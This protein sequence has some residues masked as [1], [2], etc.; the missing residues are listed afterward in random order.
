LTEGIVD[1]LLFAAGALL[2]VAAVRWWR[3]PAGGLPKRWAAAHA[4]LVFAFFGVPLTTA[5]NQAPVDIAYQFQPWRFQAEPD[6]EPDNRLLSDIPLQMVPFRTLVRDRLLAGEAPLWSH[7]TGT[8][9][10]LLGNAQSAPFAPLHLATLP[11]PPVRALTVAAAWQVLVGAL[12]MHA[13][14]LALARS[15]TPTHWPVHA[16]A[17]LAAVAFALSTYSVAWL[18][19]P[20]SMV[21]MFIPGVVLG[22]VGLARGERRAFPALVVCAW[23]LAVSGHPETA[24]HTGLLAAGL[25]LVYLAAGERAGLAVGRGRFA[26]RAALAALLTACLAAP[27][28]LPVVEILPESERKVVLDDLGRRPLGMPDFE[29]RGLLP[30]AQPL[31]FGSPRDGDW[32]GPANFNE[33]ASQYAGTATLALALAGALI[34]VGVPGRRRGGRRLTAILAAGLFALLAGLKVSPA[35][36]LVDALPLLEHAA[37]GRLRLFWVLAAALVAGLALPR[38]ARSRFGVAAGLA[39]LAGTAAVL[40][41]VLPTGSA[42]QRLWWWVALAGLGAVAAGVAVPRLR[43]LAPALA[44]AAVV[45]DLFVL[46]VHY[47]ALVPAELDL[48]PEGAPPALAF[49]VER[50]REARQPFRVTGE[51]SDLFPNLPAAYGLWGTRGNDPMQPR[52][53]S[54]LVR[55]R[56]GQAYAP[57]EN[58][59]RAGMRDPGIFRMLSVR[60]LVTPRRRRLP[61]ADWRPVFEQGAIR[62]WELRRPLPLFF[63]PARAQG[64]AE[65]ERARFAA[66]RIRD[67]E[68]R[69]V[70]LDPEECF[71]GEGRIP[72]PGGPEQEG[73]V[74][75]REVGPNGF[76]LTA[77]N[78]SPDEPLVVASSVTRVRGWRLTID[79]E[80]AEP[81]TV[82]SGFVGFRVPPGVHAVALDYA[83]AGWRWGWVLFGVGMVGAAGSMVRNRRGSPLS[84]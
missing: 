81:L 45:A 47:H 14:V 80:P 70:Y 29:A 51:G 19:H 39:A 33:Y 13:L 28:L 24:A 61:P 7:E 73:R 82:N 69:S 75:L 56:L 50:Q 8:G 57:G 12:L 22:I 3:A 44:L 68:S 63:V 15:P 79:G 40:L 5:K 66:F 58:P 9:Q 1:S 37:H 67:F 23:A 72:L 46:G 49:L 38:L 52:A 11:L 48:D 83:P 53:A 41:A 42:H 36:D 34:G 60:Y 78:R 84:F 2:I 65:A 74:W 71:R 10:P 26:G 27:A 59:A 76:E 32:D 16:G 6:F 31:A 20:L 21:A 55:R 64:L 43:R 4:L 25:G 62:V 17:A 77:E 18:Y 30:L 35:Y 54:L